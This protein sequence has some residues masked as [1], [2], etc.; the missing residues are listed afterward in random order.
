[1]RQKRNAPGI[2]RA[3]P[4]STP[5]HPVLIGKPAPLRARTTSAASANTLE[6][7]TS[8]TPITVTARTAALGRGGDSAPLSSA[9]TGRLRRDGQHRGDRGDA[10]VLL[11]P[12]APPELPGPPALRVELLPSTPAGEAARARDPEVH[13][14]SAAVDRDGDL[15]LGGRHAAGDRLERVG[16]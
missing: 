3:S 11:D 7:A 9:D 6:A 10:V 12:P 5:D 1:M 2:A 16:D 15:R 13:S 14:E 4:G 8:T